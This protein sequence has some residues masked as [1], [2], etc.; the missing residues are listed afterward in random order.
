MWR[1]RISLP[2]PENW[3]RFAAPLCVLTFGTMSP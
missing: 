2:L 3:K 1:V